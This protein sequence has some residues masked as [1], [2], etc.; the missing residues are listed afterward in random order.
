MYGVIL[1]YRI[2]LAALLGL[3]ASFQAHAIANGQPV[4][5]KQYAADYAWAVTIVHKVS[6]GICG[7]AIIAPRW[8]ITAA[9][10]TGKNKYVLVGSADRAEA[11][12]VEIER[13]IRHPGFDK[14]TLQNDVGLLY[15]AEAVEIAPATLAT[16]PESQALLRPGAS[17]SIAGWG[18]PGIGEPPARRLIVSQ[19]HLNL[20]TVLGTRITY[21][22]PETGPCGSDSGGPLL[23]RTSE[24]EPVL[25]AVISAT[26]E[27]LCAR[28][29][30]LTVVTYLALAQGFIEQQIARF[31]SG[32][33]ADAN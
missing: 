31:G 15:L 33:I 24:D 19:T 16:F 13:A 17:A 10:C 23:M 2:K 29:G 30:G 1:R 21:D 11:R 25:V 6:G 7:G 28:G 12:R 22:D 4:S 18:R 3:F 9:H 8:V 5:D 26:E 20:L 27:K 14:V 32:V